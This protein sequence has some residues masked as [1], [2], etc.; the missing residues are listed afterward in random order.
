MAFPLDIEGLDGEAPGARLARSPTGQQRAGEAYDD[1]RTR[2]GRVSREA[3]MR[4]SASAY[5]WT[6]RGGGVDD[7]NKRTRI[8]RADA[9]SEA[10]YLDLAGEALLAG[11]TREHVIAQLVSR[12]RRDESYLAYRKASNRRTRYDDQVQQDMRA[13]ALA[14]VLLEEPAQG[15]GTDKPTR[16]IGSQAHRPPT[17][18]ATRTARSSGS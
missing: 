7:M 11:M 9:G 4:P 8:S 18:A 17:K 1:R 6:A 3:A 5:R 13:L 2:A 12:I 10:N 16:R 15:K 14:A